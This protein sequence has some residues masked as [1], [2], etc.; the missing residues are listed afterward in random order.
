MSRRLASPP[1]IPCS[2][3]RCRYVAIISTP[4]AWRGKAL[5]LSCMLTPSLPVT[6]LT[7]TPLLPLPPS[8]GLVPLRLRALS[9]W[10]R[11]SLNP[12]H[13]APK[14][15]P[16]QAALCQQQPVVASVLDQPT[17]RLHQPLLHSRQRP[18]LDPLRQHQAPPQVPQV[19][20]DH[21]QPQAHLIGPEPMATQACH[22]HCLLSCL[23]PLLSGVSLVVGRRPPIVRFG[24]TLS[25]WLYLTSV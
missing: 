8:P 19:S 18:L 21:A 11:Q 13:H 25:K 5:Q 23:D 16:R 14:E 6:M 22:L 24:A 10:H 9:G 7:Q 15:L 2:W 3:R 17:S 1:Q 12:P 4:R 20:C